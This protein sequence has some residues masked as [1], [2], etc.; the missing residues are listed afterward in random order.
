MAVLNLPQVKRKTIPALNFHV[1][2]LVEIA[3]PFAALSLEDILERNPYLPDLTAVLGVCEDGLPVLLDFNDPN[4][5]AVL[6]GGSHLEG[7]TR[8]LQMTLLSALRSTPAR[9]LEVL[10]VSRDPAAWQG[11]RGLSRKQAL[12]ILP[13]YDRASGSAILRF[14]RIL[15]QRMNGR[16]HGAVHLLVVDDVHLLNQVDFDVQINFQWYAKEGAHHQMWTLGGIQ[17]ENA[18]QSDRFLTGFQTRV[19]GAVDDAFSAAWL[20]NSRPPDTSAFHPT[21]QFCVRVKR[22]W[23]NF[24]LPG[25]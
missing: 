8:M 19:L 25:R 18:E 24:W 13:I 14:S 1:A 20:A 4:P 5:G 16:S 15:D 3:N 23:L 7:V 9:D 6:V 17:A 12:E 2:P 10:V 22:N 21:Q 11:F